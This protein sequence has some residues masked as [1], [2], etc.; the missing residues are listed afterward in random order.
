MADNW[1]SFMS[2]KTPA[3]DLGISA[4]EA[5]PRPVSGLTA[6]AT[7]GLARAP[8]DSTEAGETTRNNRLAR[9]PSPPAAIA[10]TPQ[11]L[12]RGN[13]SVEPGLVVLQNWD[14]D[15]SNGMAKA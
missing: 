8:P 4:A 1:A 2:R 14:P 11:R 5:R 7:S 13:S 15:W 6:R 3:T 12:I 10:R 9:S